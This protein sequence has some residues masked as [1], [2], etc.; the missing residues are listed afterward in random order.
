VQAEQT[1][2]VDKAVSQ[3]TFLTA[4]DPSLSGSSATGTLDHQWRRQPSAERDA[5]N[6]SSGLETG[7]C[8]WGTNILD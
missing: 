8:P 1:R 4:S 3:S 6:R 2:Y 7:Q 5:D